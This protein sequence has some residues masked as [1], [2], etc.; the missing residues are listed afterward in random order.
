MSISNYLGNADAFPILRTWDFYNHAGVSPLPR[1]AGEAFRVY[2]RQ[3]EDGAYLDTAWYRDVQSFRTS[4]A[5]LIN[6]QAEE[7]ALIK[8]TSEGIAT[9][10]NGIDWRAGDR[11]VTTAVEY[12]ANMYPWM[13]VAQRYGV[14]LVRVPEQ[15]GADGRRRVPIEAILQEVDHPRTRLLTLSHVE[16]ASGQ[17]HDAATLGRFC[18]ER[19]KLFCLDAIQTVGMLPVDVLAMN[20]DYLSA[21]G[22]MWMLGPEGAGILY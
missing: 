13:D 18:R 3:A 15:T 4:A 19:G 17:R 2:T 11:I 20:V 14:E 22:H 6:A 12:P 9:V 16:F 5:K 1:V 10:A 8:N 21:D 7:I